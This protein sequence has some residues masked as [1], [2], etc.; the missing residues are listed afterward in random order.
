[1]SKTK[2]KNAP[3]K[4]VIF[5]LHWNGIIDSI[6]IESDPGF[7]LA[8]AKFADKIKENFPLHKRLLPENVPF[9]IFGSPLHQYWK[10]EFRW[11]VIQHGECMIAINEVEEGYEWKKSFEPLIINSINNIRSSYDY[12]LIFNRISLQYIDAWDIDEIEGLEFVNTKLQTEIFN[13]YQSPGK[14]KDFNLSQTFELFETTTMNIVIS[15]GVNNENGKQ[16]IILTTKAEYVGNADFNYISEW[17]EN[18]HTASSNMFKEM[19]NP[20]F[21]VSL[22]S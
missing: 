13:R 10:G 1:M 2:L 6:G 12:E 21:Y 19:L 15:T 9:K 14:L 7:E 3:L 16:S 17:I 20:D 11:P 22:D 8:Q 4:E 5:E 18:A